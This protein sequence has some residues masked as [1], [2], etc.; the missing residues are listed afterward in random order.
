MTASVRHELIAAVH[1]H[2]AGAALAVIAALLGAGEVQPVAQG[3]EQRRARVHGEAVFDAVDEQRD[4]ELALRRRQLPCR[5]AGGSVRAGRCQC[6]LLPRRCHRI[7]PA[8]HRPVQ[9]HGDTINVWMKIRTY[10]LL[11]ALA[12]LVP[13]IAFSVI[14][15]IAF[16]RQQRTVVERTGVETARAL[17]NGVDR[18]LDVDQGAGDARHRAQPPA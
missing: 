9:V 3:I 13:M 8:P 6:I 18:E 17:M 5:R 2:R 10:L 11:F 4:G 7:V 12:I 15:V 16:D 14:A 1:Q